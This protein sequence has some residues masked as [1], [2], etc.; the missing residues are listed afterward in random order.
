MSCPHITPEL[1]MQ[2]GLAG[3]KGTVSLREMKI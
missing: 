2:G 1:R 3:A